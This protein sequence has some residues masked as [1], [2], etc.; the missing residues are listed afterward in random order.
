MNNNNSTNN[1]IQ[2]LPFGQ[3]NETI[4]I[5]QIIYNIT[6]EGKPFVL[7]DNSNVKSHSISI[8][9]ERHLYTKW[10]LTQFNTLLDT[11]FVWFKMNYKQ[12]INGFIKLKI[13]KL[14]PIIY[15]FLGS[16]WKSPDIVKQ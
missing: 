13:D 10:T 1:K 15:L 11:L 14:L 6:Q 9:Q 2:V 16:T 4:Y 8:T 5:P 3:I 12:R 7:N